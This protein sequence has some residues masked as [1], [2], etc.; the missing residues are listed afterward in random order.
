[1]EKIGC[2][3]ALGKPSIFLTW[4]KK[5]KKKRNRTKVIQK[6]MHAICLA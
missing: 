4:Y 1:M 2:K 5:K 3:L 6:S